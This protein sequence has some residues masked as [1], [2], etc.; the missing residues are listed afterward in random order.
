MKTTVL[1]EEFTY[2][3]YQ[4]QPRGER[5]PL[6]AIDALGDIK[7]FTADPDFQPKAGWKIISLSEQTQPVVNG[8]DSDQ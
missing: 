6:I 2:E 8:T 3:D 1:T 4:Q 7:V 5:V